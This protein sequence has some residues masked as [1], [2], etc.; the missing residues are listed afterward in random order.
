LGEGWIRHRE[1]S[2]RSTKVVS[3]PAALIVSPTAVHAD[4]PLQATPASELTAAPASFGDR[5]T[6]HL[7][8]FHRSAKV[9]PALEAVT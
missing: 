5:W 8:P 9:T 2:H 7:P 4:G 3:V 6:R 1:P